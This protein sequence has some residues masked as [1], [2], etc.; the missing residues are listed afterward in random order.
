MQKVLNRSIDQLPRK[1]E[2]MAHG[3]INHAN[4]VSA[5]LRNRQEGGG[6]DGLASRIDYSLAALAP[7]IS[8]LRSPDSTTE[9]NVLELGPGRT[10]HIAAAFALCGAGSVVGLDIAANIDSARVRSPGRYRDLAKSLTDGRAS[11]L[12]EALGASSEAV[13]ARVDSGTPLPIAFGSFEGDII[14]LPTSSIDL[15]VSW[16]TLEHVRNGSIGTLL[17]E[18]RRVLRPGGGM[19]HWIDIRDHFRITGFLTAEGDWLRALRYS[20]TEYEQMFSKRPV[21]VNRLRSS[22]WHEKFQNAGFE[23]R[24]WNEHRLPLPADFDRSTIDPRWRNLSD[25]ELEVSVIEAS[26]SAAK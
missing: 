2:V 23:I 11:A 26:L 13:R 1:F 15:I 7:G 4:R 22:E 14:P 24:G 12:R 18:L 6:M 8:L 16:S 5:W 20:D 9:W 10:P 21:Y 17:A 25:D 3:A 19:A